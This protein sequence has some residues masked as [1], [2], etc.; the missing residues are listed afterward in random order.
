MV[1]GKGAIE[2]R[3]INPWFVLRNG[4]IVVLHGDLRDRDVGGRDPHGF[5]VSENLSKGYII[6]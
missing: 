5:A 1:P 6:P 2:K 4:E 3:L